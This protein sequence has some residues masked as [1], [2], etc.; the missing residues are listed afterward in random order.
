MQ[1]REGWMPASWKALLMSSHFC[2]SGSE[3]VHQRT[4]ITPSTVGQAA[5]NRSLFMQPVVTPPAC[6]ASPPPHSLAFP[7]QGSETQRQGRAASADG[8]L[9]T[10]L[11]TELWRIPA[12]ELRLGRG[13]HRPR[14]STGSV[15]S[16]FLPSSKRGAGPGFHLRAVSALLVKTL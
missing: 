16:K 8:W 9:R 7:R 14:A 10:Q 15:T 2:C 4:S 11:T 13:E 1:R 12:M 5:D 3:M 6:L